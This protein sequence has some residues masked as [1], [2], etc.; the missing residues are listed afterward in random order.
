VAC[1]NNVDVASTPKPALNRQRRFRSVKADD[2]D[3]DDVDVRFGVLR[4]NKKIAKA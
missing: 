4:M 2:D 1:D 3:D